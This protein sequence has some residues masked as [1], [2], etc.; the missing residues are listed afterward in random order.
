MPVKEVND[1]AA[2]AVRR[3]ARAQ[4]QAGHTELSVSLAQW[5]LRGVLPHDKLPLTSSS[6]DSNEMAVTKVTEIIRNS[7]TLWSR[8]PDHLLCNVNFPHFLSFAL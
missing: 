6:C 5:L 1:T 7:R 3:R 8:C 2:A 4:W